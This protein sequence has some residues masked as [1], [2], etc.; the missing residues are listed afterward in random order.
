MD[1]VLLVTYGAILLVDA[2]WTQDCV[3]YQDVAA[4]QSFNVYSP[5]YPNNYPSG[6]S[7]SWEAVAPS[8]SHFILQCNEFST[9]AV[10]EMLGNVTTPLLKYSA[11]AFYANFK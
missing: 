9:P 5:N 8:N 7:C 3:Y 1:A 6:I 10:S 11:V 2:V 4:G